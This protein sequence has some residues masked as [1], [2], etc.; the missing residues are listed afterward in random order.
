MTENDQHERRSRL[1]GSSGG[2]V[3][4]DDVVGCSILITFLSNRF[5]ETFAAVND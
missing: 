5:P 1:D 4:I 3:P 2:F